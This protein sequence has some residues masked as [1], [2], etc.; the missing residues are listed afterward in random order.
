MSFLQANLRT[1]VN[2]VSIIDQSN[3]INCL[4]HFHSYL[5]YEILHSAVMISYQNSSVSA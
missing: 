1:Q 3:K 2:Y 5:T 4:L